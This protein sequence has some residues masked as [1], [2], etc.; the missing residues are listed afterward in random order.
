MFQV[1][2][3]YRMTLWPLVALGSGFTGMSVVA[4]IKNHLDIILNFVL[5]E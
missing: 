4:C 2:Q 5:S 3:A 1:T